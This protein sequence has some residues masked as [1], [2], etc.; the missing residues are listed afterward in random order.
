M[1]TTIDDMIKYL[2]IILTDK[3]DNLSAEDHNNLICMFHIIGIR[4]I[5][6]IV[7]LKFPIEI[8]FNRYLITYSLNNYGYLKPKLLCQI[9]ENSKLIKIYRTNYINLS[10]ITDNIMKMFNMMCKYSLKQ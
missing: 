4:N 9:K 1:I 6:N 2:N 8:P 3:V 5:A 7:N 10:A